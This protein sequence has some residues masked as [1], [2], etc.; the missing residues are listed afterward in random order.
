MSDIPS[1]GDIP[2]FFWVSFAVDINTKSL[3]IL[4]FFLNKTKDEAMKVTKER[5]IGKYDGL[6]FECFNFFSSTP[7]NPNVFRHDMT[8]WLISLGLEYDIA[9]DTVTGFF[10]S[11]LKLLNEAKDNENGV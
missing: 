1:D 11:F 10:K 9:I 5:A 2:K 7:E 4:G 3:Y 6:P 8:N